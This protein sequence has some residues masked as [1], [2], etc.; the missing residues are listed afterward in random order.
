MMS[1]SKVH[2]KHASALHLL[3]DMSLFKLNASDL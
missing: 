3:A 1:K 2:E